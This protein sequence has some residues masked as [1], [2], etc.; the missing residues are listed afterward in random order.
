[1]SNA[2]TDTR[3]VGRLTVDVLDNRSALGEAAAA[4]IADSIRRLLAER[5]SIRIVFA[6]APSQTETLAALAEAEGIDWARV[7]AFHM[8]EYVGIARDAP[9]RFG[10]WLR[11]AFFDRVP[12]RSVELIDPDGSTA[13]DGSG[14]AA[15]YAALL[16][17]EPVDIVLAGI[18]VTGHLAFNDPPVDFDE[19]ASVKVVA[20]D[21]ESRV[22][23]VA[24]GLF[25]E[26]DE[27][28]THAWTLTVPSL[29][30]AGEIFC[31]VPGALKTS[32]VRRAL[33]GA[34]APDSPAS[35]L[36]VHPRARLFLDR[37]ASPFHADSGE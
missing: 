32:A 18:G 1:V 21:R 2:T 37:D 23:Q 26:L 13:T 28:P 22:Q 16:E 10:N 3:V 30:S 8:D 27:V 7:D 14:E 35:A 31:V 15:R 24:E 36:R 9:Q 20:L 17:A 19:V 5:G 11:N 6:A 12:L 29:L 25:P 33:T 34:V 4:A